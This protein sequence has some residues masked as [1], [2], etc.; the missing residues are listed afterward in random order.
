MRKAA[1]FYIAAGVLLLGLSVGAWR[2]WHGSKSDQPL[3]GSGTG[4]VN[5][6]LVTTQSKR[7]WVTDQIYQFN[8]THPQVH[9]TF[10][11]IESRSAMQA[12]LFGK[13]TP[14]LW[15][16]DSPSLVTALVD[17]W[18]KAHHTTIVDT[19]NPET[20][21]VFQR[22]PLVFLTTK[23]KALYLRPILSSRNPWE[24]I[25]K[26]GASPTSTPWHSFS[27]VHADPT[28]DATGLLMLALILNAYASDRGQNANLPNIASSDDFGQYL[29]QVEQGLRRSPNVG[30]FDI[31]KSYIANTSSAD[32]IVTTESAALAAAVANPNLAV[33][34][35]NPTAVTE[36]SVCILNG[37]WL[38]PDKQQA[39]EQF[40][41]YISQSEATK[42]GIK[43]YMRPAS[44]AE[45]SSYSP[46]LTQHSSQGF[47]PLYSAVELPSYATLN[48]AL[49]QWCKHVSHTQYVGIK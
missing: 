34:Y 38:T 45:D 3:A 12:I 48:A 32:F 42:S 33:I 23:T 41:Q 49:F 37:P 9:V 40:M 6:S 19:T 17:N 10:K 22:S 20:F 15:S 25:R 8:Y 31:T 28:N 2:S 43:L 35:P 46:R 27:F 30:T 14:D 29:S 24:G 26:L 13:E 4:V 39:A 21:R 7:D 44:G 5:I 36:E 1:T 18:S 11:F 47:S 16:P